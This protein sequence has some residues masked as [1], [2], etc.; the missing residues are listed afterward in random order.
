[1]TD[2]NPIK[3]LI[4]RILAL[5]G[6]EIRNTRYKAVKRLPTDPDSVAA[7]TMQGGE[8]YSIYHSPVPIYSPW[9]GY[10]GFSEA[11]EGVYKN[12]LVSADRCY[13][14]HKFAL[15]ASRL[16]EGNLAEAGVY[17]GGTALI[18]SRAIQGSGKKLFLFD[19][20]QGLPIATPEHDN[21]YKEGDFA[22]S[23]DACAKLLEKYKD[24]IQF[25]VGWIPETFIGLEHERFA[26]VHV[27]VDLYQSSMDCLNFFYP[28]LVDGGVMIFDDYGFPACKGEKDAVDQFFS[29]KK[30]KPISLPTGQSLIIRIG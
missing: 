10:D 13:I 8:C 9:T 21:F 5:L 3:I 29:D 26:Y 12:T 19:S 2:N 15:Y 27:D 23:Y 16:K 18:N 22:A 28:R 24:F 30:E 11:Y 7:R 4:K 17:K 20:F 1:M 14:L 25:R 6:Y